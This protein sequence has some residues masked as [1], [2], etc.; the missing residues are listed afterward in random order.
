A[1]FPAELG[2]RDVWVQNMRRRIASERE[3]HAQ[4]YIIID[5]VRFENEAELIREM[6]GCVIRVSRSKHD[7][8]GIYAD[9]DPACVSTQKHVSETEMDT[10][11]PDAFVYNTAA[12][13][14]P[15]VAKQIK[16][17]IDKAQVP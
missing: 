10:I 8:H 14:L 6:G 3:R 1:H 9:E 2:G 15:L 17:F 16:R 12:G 5:D 11:E 4:T 13:I 7:E